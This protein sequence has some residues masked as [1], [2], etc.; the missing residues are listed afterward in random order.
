[1][2]MA[3]SLA[4][5]SLLLP[6]ARGLSEAHPAA[7][8]AR[9]ERIESPARRPARLPRFA[10]AMD[11]TTLLSWVEEEQLSSGRAL[12]RLRFAALE[13][14]G[15]S[16]ARSVASGERWFL[17]WADFPSLAALDGRRLLAHY[18]ERSGG[19]AHDYRVRI[20]GSAD[21]G[22][23]WSAPRALHEHD[24]PGEH[25]FVSLVPLGER[26]FGAFWLDGRGAL[27]G[28]A[29]GGH[30][31]HGSMALYARTVGLD[32][33]LGAE[34]VVDERVC[35][36]CPTSALALASGELLVAYRD[37]SEDELRDI[38]IARVAGAASE[39]VWESG[40]G[41][42]IA[43]CPVNGPVL[44][45]SGERVAVVWFTVGSQNVTRVHWALSPDGGK[46]FGLARELGRGT[47][48]G[49]VDA[50][51]DE[52]GRLLILWLDE[53]GERNA[54]RLARVDSEGRL[55]GEHELASVS[56]GRESGH[57]RLAS[58]PGSILVALTLAEETPALEILRVSWEKAPA[59][60]A[61]EPP[62]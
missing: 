6:L 25:G 16:A 9:V 45:A 30:G 54:W 4:L 2:S 53:Q 34:R 31:G 62:R 51:F 58:V 26:G 18:L 32:G 1:M 19:G 3:R 33:E 38:A 59:A 39:R 49:R 15:W 7:G 44:C 28:G 22:S 47:A 21:G 23:S 13:G 5:C 20:L 50:L 42:R 43:G 17:N 48:L 41:W 46:T 61:G 24:G 35:D 57:A 11:G 8:D 12:A 27:A 55:L 56:P 37:R 10:R 60:S 52:A 29:H 36:C 40:D 14:E